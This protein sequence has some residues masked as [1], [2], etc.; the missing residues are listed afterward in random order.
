MLE[1]V[2][3]EPGADP[4]V[5]GSY[6]AATPAKVFQAWTDPNVVMRWFGSQP[7]SLHSA[8]I[9]L[10]PGGVW[11]FLEFKDDEHSI[12]FEGKY[13]EIEPDKRLV[14]TWSKFTSG[15]NGQRVTSPPSRVEVSLSA[16][17]TGTDVRLVHSAMHSEELRRGFAG[18][19]D[20]AFRTMSAMFADA[21]ENSAA[22]TKLR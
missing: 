20:R 19:W 3:T 13:V 12:G 18:G 22:N 11:C 17:G 5:A 2:K 16:N 15:A 4:I 6:F 7:N 10:R 9:D 8:T 21:G 14:F 1:F